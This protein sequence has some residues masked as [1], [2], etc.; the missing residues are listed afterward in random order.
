M[1]CCNY[2]GF[3]RTLNL[4]S[5]INIYYMKSVYLSL[6]GILFLVGSFF[7][8]PLNAQRNCGATEYLEMQ[9]QQQNF[10]SLVS[11]RH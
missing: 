11:N 7:T 5:V 1:Q 8:N 2:F 9:M 4:L 6:I 10:T 3:Y